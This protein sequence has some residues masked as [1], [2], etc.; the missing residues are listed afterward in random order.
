MPLS[1]LWE[2][3]RHRPPLDSAPYEE[4]LRRYPDE[5][6]AVFNEFMRRLSELVF[7]AAVDLCTRQ[8]LVAIRERAAELTTS[9]FH[10]FVPEMG[11]G[12]PEM[13][14]RRFAMTLRNVLDEDAFRT[15][16]RVYYRHLP[17]YHL[18][19]RDQRRCLEA[20]FASG[21]SAT[22]Q[23]IAERLLL[24]VARV[25]KLLKAGNLEL[26]R[27]VKEDYEEAELREMT[28]GRLP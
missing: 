28:E 24:P 10:A 27:V 2:W 12:R 5:R 7:L 6:A 26:A 20:M 15:I 3:I 17:L 1:S 19:N 14:L 23:Q 18:R 8:G 9:A 21:L 4:L 25:V 16:E 11:T 13:V 22:P